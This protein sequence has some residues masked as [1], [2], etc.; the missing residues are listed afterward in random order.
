MHGPLGMVMGQSCED[1]YQ[2]WLEPEWLELGSFT[3]WGLSWA[4]GVFYVIP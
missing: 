1:Q 2:K 3:I 4:R